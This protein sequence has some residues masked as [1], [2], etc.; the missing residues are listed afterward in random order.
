MWMLLGIALHVSAR[1]VQVSEHLTYGQ[2]GI[3]SV[4]RKLIVREGY[5]LLHDE[6]KKDPLWVSYRLTKAY[7]NKAVQRKDQFAPDP[8]LEEGRRAEL[9]DYKGSSWSRGHM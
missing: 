4:G 8:L 5:A 2:P 7:T 9:S 1:P 3:D 6:D